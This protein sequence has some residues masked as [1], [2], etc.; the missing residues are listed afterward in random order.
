MLRLGRNKLHTPG[1]GGWQLCR[2]GLWGYC[3]TRLTWASYVPF[4]QRMP[5]ASWKHTPSNTFLPAGWERWSYPSAQHWWGHT[6]SAVSSFGILSTKETW[7]YCR[8]SNEEPQKRLMDWSTSLL[9]G[10]A[11]STGTLHSGRGKARMYKWLMED[12]KNMEPDFPIVSI[13]KTRKTDIN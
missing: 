5:M 1:Q 12:I 2:K 3:W 6:W 7:T 9:Q 10:K 13:Y 8:E 11:E 4:W